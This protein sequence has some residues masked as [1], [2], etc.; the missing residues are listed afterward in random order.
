MDARVLR[1][2]RN[3]SSGSRKEL[4]EGLGKALVEVAGGTL[5][6]RKAKDG[7]S[8]VLKRAREGAPQVIGSSP[9]A[10]VV[11]SMNDLVALLGA[12]KEPTFGDALRKSG[13]KPFR[14]DRV[15]VSQGA[16]R[17][18][19]KRRAASASAPSV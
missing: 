1:Q 17:E 12:A 3:A 13:F 7:L 2:I 9:D 16:P 6:V 15:I 14:G 8:G 5:T 4:L 10:A 19:L 18:T 11:I